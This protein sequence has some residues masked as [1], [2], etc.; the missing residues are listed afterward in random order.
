MA[1]SIEKITQEIVELSRRERLTLLRFLLE[2]DQPSKGEETE[3]AWDREIRALWRAKKHVDLARVG[4][5]R[6]TAN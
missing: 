2:L 4:K 6:L 5:A 1:T 3:Q